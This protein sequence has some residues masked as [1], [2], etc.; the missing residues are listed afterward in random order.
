M[1]FF[2]NIILHLNELKDDI[3]FKKYQNVF[4]T[5]DNFIFLGN[6]GSNAISSHI[7]EDFLLHKKTALSFSDTAMMSCFSNDFKYENIFS[8]YLSHYATNKTF[9]VLI[10]SSGNSLNIINAIDYCENNI[11]SY[12]ILTGFDYN[13]L[14]RIK[15]KKYCLFDYHVNSHNYGVV[16]CVHQ[17]FLH[18]LL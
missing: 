18:G 7:T 17:I 4:N 13:N 12:G 10:S 9:I 2:E 8:K 11:L 15:H 5:H 6:G 16:E 1:N 14:A 3:E